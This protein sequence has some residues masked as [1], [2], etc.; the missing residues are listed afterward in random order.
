[1]ISAQQAQWVRDNYK[2]D[3]MTDEEA[4]AAY[5]STLKEGDDSGEYSLMSPHACIIKE[6]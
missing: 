2:K 3:G 1:M 6:S 5:L 4:L